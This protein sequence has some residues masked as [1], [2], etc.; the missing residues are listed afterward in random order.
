MIDSLFENGKVWIANAIQNEDGRTTIPISG[1]EEVYIDSSRNE[2]FLQI[3]N[4]ALSIHV[5]T[6]RE[7]MNRIHI[8]SDFGFDMQLAL[9]A[10]LLVPFE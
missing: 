2:D 4:F 1:R 3:D 5:Q 6:Y 7:G 8:Y 10:E 9:R